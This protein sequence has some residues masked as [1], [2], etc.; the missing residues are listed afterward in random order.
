[1]CGRYTLINPQNLKRR[2]KTENKVKELDPSFNIAPSMYL[3]TITRNSPNKVT[4]MKWGF[5]PEWS[6]GNSF[7]MINI[8]DDTLKTKIYF[9]KWTEYS[10]IAI[11]PDTHP[12]NSTQ[13]PWKEH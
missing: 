7:S 13:G 6:K 8:R 10:G 2:Y 5:V 11:W 4:Y 3:P 9:Q 1:M 12:L